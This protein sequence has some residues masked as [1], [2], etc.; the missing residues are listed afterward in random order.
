MFVAR[1]PASILPEENGVGFLV[2]FVD[3]PEALTSGDDFSD[4]LVQAADCLAE[5]D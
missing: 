2:R 5:G 4:S 1:Y 3:L